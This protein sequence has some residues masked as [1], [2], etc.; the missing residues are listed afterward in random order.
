[1]TWKVR[2]KSWSPGLKKVGLTKLIREAADLP[3]NEAHDAVNRLLA[4]EAVELTLPNKRDAQRFVDDARAL[5]VQ[6]ECV[7]S[8]VSAK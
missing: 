3:L 4:D 7:A 2:L 1:V 8:E 6:A 5:G